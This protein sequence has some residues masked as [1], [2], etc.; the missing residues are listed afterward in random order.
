MVAESGHILKTP[1]QQQAV[2]TVDKSL[3]VSAAAGSGKTTVLADR[4]V[5]LVCDADRPCDVDELLVVTFTEAA[6][7]EMKSRI[8]Q[9]L[10][11]R[12]ASQPSENLARQLALIDQAQVS[13]LHGFCAR[14]LRQ[15]FHIAGVDPAFRIL[16]GQ[17]ARLLR[18]QIARE[19][20]RDSYG[21]L[22]GFEHFID[23]YGDG[24]DERLVSLLF[25]THEMLCSLTDPNSW[26][27]AADR[28]LAQ[29]TSGVLDETLLGAALS[30]WVSAELGDLERRCSD[31]LRQLRQIKFPV[32]ERYVQEHF[33]PVISN[34]RAIFE[35][36]G[37]D[38]LVQ[39]LEFDFPRLPSVSN[40]LPNKDR[41]F[42]VIDD[43]KKAMTSGKWRTVLRFSSEQWQEGM[44]ATLPHARTLFELIKQFAIRYRRAKDLGRSLDFAD[45]ERC[46]LKMLGGKGQPTETARA[47]HR[48]Y[49][50][51]LVD[52]YQD[53]NELQDEILKL[54]SD[55]P[56]L[57]CVGDVKQSIY[58]FRLA[59]PGL[60]LKREK[61]F[62][63]GKSGGK[64]IDLQKNFR[65]RK[66]LLEAINSVFERLMT[67]EAAEIQYDQ[68]HRL[69][70]GQT[71]PPAEDGRTF[72]GAPIEL[73]LLAKSD[74]SENE[75]ENL[76]QLERE[77]AFVAGRI[78]Q[79]MGMEPGTT[80]MLIADR[81]ADGA[82]ILRPIR[83]SDI[84]IL[85]RTMR[86]KSE[87][88]ARILAARK[89]PVHA[90]SVT[91][92]FES[93]EVRDMLALLQLL[94]NQQQD[95]PLAALLRGP[96]AN[97]TDADDAMA[98]IRLA[99][100][101]E[102][103]FHQAVT[104][105]AAE[106]QDELAK[107]VGK[108][109]ADLQR[110]REAAGRRPLH[111]V[112]WDIF[113]ETGLLAFCEGLPAGAQRVAN[114]LYFHERAATFG[115]FQRQGLGH[116]LEFLESLREESDIGLPAT[117]SR[118]AEVVRIMSVHRSKGLEFPVVFLPDLGKRINLQDTQGSILLDRELGI[119]LMVVD[120]LRRV[121]YPS[122]ASTLVKNRLHRQAMAE[123]LRV[124]YVA[125]T[126]AKE[127]LVMVGTTTEK[128]LQ[129]WQSQ[130]AGRVGPLPSAE[131]LGA[132]RVLDWIGPL[133]AALGT[134]TFRT[135]FH[136]SEPPSET[137]KTAAAAPAS[138]SPQEETGPCPA[139]DAVIQRLTFHYPHHGLAQIPAAQSVTGR[140]EL[141]EPDD[142]PDVIR[143]APL[144]RVLER[145]DFLVGQVVFSATERG[146]ATHLVLQ[147]LDFRRPCDAADVAEQIAALVARRAISAAAAKE[148]D[149]EAIVWFATSDVGQLLRQNADR[150]RRE[151]AV[152]FAA[153]SFTS[154][155]TP[156]EA[157]WGPERIGTSALPPPP[158]PSSGV[159]G[160]GENAAALDEVMVRGRLDL[161]LPLADGNVIVDYKT[162]AVDENSAKLRAEEY[163]PQMNLYRH[164]IERITGKPVK[165]VHLV[166]MRPRRSIRI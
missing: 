144:P 93:M 78:R 5:H 128:C 36:D 1:A 12:A 104:R 130:W 110:W 62:R 3:L 101:G 145:P 48:R 19:L 47:C 46:T 136:T 131:V 135:T 146:T 53:I 14:L 157:G 163:R 18:Q 41:A 83:F 107:R 35:G 43:L 86:F 49:R 44:R 166:F 82:S 34:L 119:G 143:A 156:R 50:H 10:R 125:M 17:E 115:S 67:A 114:L 85:L 33:L 27:R 100:P 92:Y 122:L 65:S 133:A 112:I 94:D 61:S 57:F 76:D 69:V 148:V 66:P 109:L 24:D 155:G 141:A 106:K 118:A 25:N 73:E 95:I 58:R 91:G 55:G 84:V 121:R 16:D 2:V 11:R 105:Y 160:E 20:F 22:T 98:R 64:V 39:S 6:A 123:E 138:Q 87:Q 88:F 56:N 8:A 164:A 71:F 165:D 30:E 74:H 26:L 59:E 159:P 31:V 9:S 154:P 116:F 63:D 99:Y 111:E 21:S 97:L 23:C 153:P 45:L 150:L 161:L 152:Y 80:P 75:D 40:S 102:T 77:A 29:V 158:Q 113:A 54:V 96:L 108:I 117:S 124:L 162:D 89:I 68:H 42:A 142:L 51:V 134:S 38:A 28:R 7:A 139:A 13:T 147:H 126:R 32:Y 15:N 137:T 151:I 127:H 60:F 79:M 70:H 81:D 72:I 149:Q 103:P 132:K 120:E 129:C 37:L 52:E 140:K 90:D 4:C